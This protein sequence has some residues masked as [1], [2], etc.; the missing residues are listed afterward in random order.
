MI[1]NLQQLFQKI[2]QEV[3]SQSALLKTG[4]LRESADIVV[5]SQ[6][7]SVFTDTC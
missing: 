6:I 5:T 2:L 3:S 1:Y 7:L 4:L